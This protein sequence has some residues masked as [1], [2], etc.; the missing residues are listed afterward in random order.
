MRPRPTVGEERRG[1]GGTSPNDEHL[2]SRHRTVTHEHAAAVAAAAHLQERCHE[3]VVG[4]SGFFV[5][6]H[7]P[8]PVRV[9]CC[10]WSTWT[11]ARRGAPC[12]SSALGDGDR[13]REGNVVLS[14]VVVDEDGVDTC[15]YSH[16]VLRWIRSPRELERELLDR[17][18]APCLFVIVV[19]AYGTALL[20]CD[21][22]WG[23]REFVRSLSG[24]VRPKRYGLRGVR[25]S[26][27]PPLLL[28][29]VRGGCH[30]DC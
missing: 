1:G 26:S 6:L 28:S 24:A 16:L 22:P 10:C 5:S 20:L 12:A 17:Q 13:A 9:C 2:A 18:T 15:F 8:A 3:R 25:S 4:P 11:A 30:D 7:S 23:C 27:S 19:G 29:F 21:P 14:G